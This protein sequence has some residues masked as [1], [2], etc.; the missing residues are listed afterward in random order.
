MAGEA[1][2]EATV[3]WHGIDG[4]RRSAFVPSGSRS[5]FP[6]LTIRQAPALTRYVPRGG[7][8]RTPD[9]RLLDLESEELAAE[10]AEAHGGPVHLHRDARGLVD[11]FPVSL[12]SLQAVAAVGAIVG[13]ELE[14]HRFRTSF[15]ADLP[16][17]DAEFPE[18][19]LVGRTIALG[20]E[21]QVRLDL[22]DSRCMVVNFDPE[23]AERD[24][25][26]LRAIVARRQK[27]LGVYGSVV[28]PGVV[29]VG[30]PIAVVA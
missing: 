1:L 23:T 15:V 26:V 28:R 13:R 7:T 11:A 27:C 14:P 2:D 4:D 10:L 6:W 29:R 24:P 9:G 19:A 21:L 18:D 22:R 5:D 20:D 17:G 8:V 30:D 25:S 12:M 3:G 16:G